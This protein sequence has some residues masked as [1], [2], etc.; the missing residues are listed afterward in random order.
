MA[1]RT[2]SRDAPAALTARLAQLL[3]EL[4]VPF[5]VAPYEADSQLGYLYRAGIVDLVV[6]EDSDALVYGCGLVLYKFTLE[7]GGGDLIALPDVLT[8][9]DSPFRGFTHDMVRGRLT[10]SRAAP[11]QHALTALPCAQFVDA[12]VLMGCDYAP[13]LQGVGAKTAMRYARR[14]LCID[15]VRVPPASPRLLHPPCAARPASR[16]DTRWWRPGAMR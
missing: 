15:R 11:F 5:I 12:C 9:P 3:H 4:R 6:T 14:H 10:H 1:G 13:S 7:G 2:R 16:G 8:H